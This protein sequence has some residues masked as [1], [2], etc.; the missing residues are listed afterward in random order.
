MHPCDG[1]HGGGGG[2]AGASALGAGP[3]VGSGIPAAQRSGWPAGPRGRQGPAVGARRARGHPAPPPAGR[4]GEAS[5]GSGALTSPYPA[6]LSGTRRDAAVRREERPDHYTRGC[7]T[8]TRCQS[9]ADPAEQRAGAEKVPSCHAPSGRLG[10]CAGAMLG[11]ELARRK[12]LSSSAAGWNLVSVSWSTG[13]WAP[14]LGGD[15]SRS[16]APVYTAT[17]A[18]H[19]PGS[20]QKSSSRQ[21]GPGWRLLPRPALW[22]YFC[23]AIRLWPLE[24][25][26][27][28]KQKPAD[29][30]EGEAD[31]TAYFGLRYSH[32][33]FS[34]VQSGRRENWVRDLLG[35]GW[36]AS[37]FKI[38]FS[39]RFALRNF[40][41]SISNLQL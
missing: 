1:S 16:V 9:P 27:S 30:S 37:A 40:A 38:A 31:T 24:Q 39:L 14:G 15:S 19:P 35:N 21:S 41:S 8:P 5:G 2:L 34:K 3:A 28:E 36:R 33:K 6:E 7:A 29:I 13:L 25:L 22:L 11:S 32:P 4:W 17:P 20:S 10:V 23:I 26:L 12:W 18:A